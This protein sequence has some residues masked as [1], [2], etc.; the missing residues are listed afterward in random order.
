M[1]LVRFAGSFFYWRSA[2]GFLTNRRFF[3]INGIGKWW[4]RWLKVLTF[5]KPTIYSVQGIIMADNFAAQV[6]TTQ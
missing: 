5:M 3:F 2:N 1:M 6:D 4:N